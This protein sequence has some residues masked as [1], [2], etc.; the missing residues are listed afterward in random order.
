MT[1]AAASGA[2]S[3]VTLMGA[4]TADWFAGFVSLLTA[5][6]ASAAVLLLLVDDCAR[7][8]T[9]AVGNGARGG[10]DAELLVDEGGVSTAVAGASAGDQC[11]WHARPSKFKVLK[12]QYAAT[13]A[14]SGLHLH[15]VLLRW[16]TVLSYRAQA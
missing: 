3:S 1:F 6:D 15:N 4:A 11:G 14:A 10:A 12:K 2:A 9:D 13:Q 7:L 16:T 5:L 8:G